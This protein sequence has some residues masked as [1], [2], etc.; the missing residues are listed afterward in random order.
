LATPIFQKQQPRADEGVDK[1]EAEFGENDDVFAPGELLSRPVLRDYAGYLSASEAGDAL[2]ASL[3]S[4]T[5]TQTVKAEPSSSIIADVLQPPPQMPPALPLVQQAV[6]CNDLA[7][8]RALLAHPALQPL[9]LQ[10]T[11]ARGPLHVACA[12]GRLEAATLLLQAGA[13]PAAA[14]AHHVQPIHLASQRGPV[15][16][17]ELLWQRG[18]RAALCATDR[19]AQTPLHYASRA[20]APV[21]VVE[22]LIATTPDRVDPRDRWQRTPL[23]CCFDWQILRNCFSKK[24]F[25]VALG[26]R[27]WPPRHSTRTCGGRCRRAGSRFI[28]RDSSGNCRAAGPLWSCTAGR[29]AAER[30]W[31]YCHAPWRVGKVCQRSPSELAYL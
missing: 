25:F 13:P 22:A 11:H 7:T 21:R 9:P 30:F 3:S 28:H 5:T 1:R 31:G 12:L 24:G 26:R 8:L 19:D 18:G 17:L 10:P 6:R 23:V 14:D 27:Q 29:S 20:G 2:S 4:S 15:A 16:L